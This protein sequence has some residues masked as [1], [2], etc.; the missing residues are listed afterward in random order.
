M[1]TPPDEFVELITNFEG[2]KRTGYVPKDNSGAII[3]SSGVTIG[4]GLDLGHQDE[5]SLR[6]MGLE[7]PL[8]DKLKPYVGY[9]GQDALD[10]ADTLSITPEEE[11]E[12]NSKVTSRYWS[13][14]NRN[15][16]NYV[17]YDSS[18]LPTKARFAVASRFFNSGSSIFKGT[19]FTKQLANRDYEAAADNLETWFNPKGKYKALVPR[20]RKEAALF[21]EGFAEKDNQPGFDIAG[22]KNIFGN[23]L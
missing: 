10:I 2:T 14:F 12:L 3:G 19:R 6:T 16:K 4:K 23:L 21:R 13:E 17:G 18:E 22:F 15:F 1:E 8:L 7:G 9:R 11:K 20:V 5:N